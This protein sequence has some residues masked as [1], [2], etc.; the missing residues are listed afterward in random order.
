[1]DDVT[2]TFKSLVEGQQ[3]EEVRAIYRTDLN[4]LSD[5]YKK[6]EVDYV[7]W[8]LMDPEVRMKH[9]AR[10]RRYKPTLDD[11]VDKLKSSLKNTSDRKRTRKLDFQS[12]FDWLDKKER[13]SRKSLTFQDPN[14]PEK[15]LLEL[16]FHSMVPGLVNRCQGN[17]GDKLFPVYI[18]DYLVVMSD[19]RISFMNKQREMNS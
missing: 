5:C 14:A 17:C 13:K 11:Q 9:V 18:E 6:S 7:K 16:F 12:A 1:M 3:D 2:K 10:F 15:I 4:R 8:P 19:G